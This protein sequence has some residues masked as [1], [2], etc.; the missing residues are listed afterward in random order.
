M[1]EVSV[2]G[3]G[4]FEGSEANVVQ[5]LVINAHNLISILD[6]LM[7]REGSVVGLNDGIGDLG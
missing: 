4:E 6:Q 3:G 2:G 1:V 7:D 5:S